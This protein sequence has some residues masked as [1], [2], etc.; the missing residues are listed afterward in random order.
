MQLNPNNLPERE[1]SRKPDEAFE[2]M[3]SSY[4]FITPTPLLGRRRKELI[5]NGTTT[6]SP[7]T[8]KMVS[9]RTTNRKLDHVCNVWETNDIFESCQT[10]EEIL[11][12]KTNDLELKRP[13]T[14]HAHNVNVQ[15][16]RPTW[17]QTFAPAEPEMR[18]AYP[19]Q[20]SESC[21]KRR[22]R[23]RR[24]RRTNE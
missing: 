23:R 15:L 12:R 4:E 13:Y 24:R 2:I 21:R 16:Q 9:R 10:Q 20:Q 14:F 3:D 11:S 18:R 22:R 17:P 5:R 19:K 6:S 7:G 8:H 1:S